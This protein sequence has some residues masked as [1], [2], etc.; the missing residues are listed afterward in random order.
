MSHPFDPNQLQFFLTIPS[1][2]PYLPGRMERKIFTQLDPLDGPHLNN[3]LTHAGFRRSQNVIYRP[4]CESCRECRSLRVKADM[5]EPG[6]SFRRTIARNDDLSIEVAPAIATTEQFALLARYLKHRHPGGGMT[7]MDMS[8]YE[9]M[10]EECA[11]E[12]EIVEYREPD[13]TLIAC[14]LIDRLMDGLSLVYSFFDTDAQARSLG[15][16]MILDQI[17]RARLE[18]LPYLYLGYW[19]PGSPKMDYKMRFRPAEVLGHRG[20]MPLQTPTA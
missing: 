12:T 14:M 11:S 7:D 17:G 3:Y 5:F 15:N 13:G 1:P 18:G 6:R 10:V 16:Y 8:R 20:W 9:M 19:V 4:A 2:C